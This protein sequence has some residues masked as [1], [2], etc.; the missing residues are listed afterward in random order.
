MNYQEALE[1]I[2]SVN[3]KG[4]RPG[5]GRITELCE[6]LGNPQKDLRFIHVAGTNGKGS[7]C[8]MLMSILRA[9]GYEAGT[10][11]SPYIYKFEERMA[12][13][14]K[15]I[16]PEELAEI[17]SYVAPHAD[18]ME[19][20]PTEFELI[21]AIGFE[22]FKRRGCR[23]VILEAGMGGRLDSTNVIPAPILSVITGIA[24]DHTEYLGDTTEAI[25]KEKAGIIKPGSMV[26]WGG[27]DPDAERVILD[28]ATECECKC[29]G[30]DYSLLSNVKLSIDGTTFDFGR[31]AGLTLPLLG[32]YQ[33]YNA[34]RVITATEILRQGGVKITDDAVRIGLANAKWYG[35]FELMAREPDI[36]FDGAHNPEGMEHAVA[37]IKGYYPDKMVALIMGVMKDKDYE[38]MIKTCAPII[39]HAFTVTP[40]NPRALTA[41]ELAHAF[42]DN[43]IYSTAFPSIEGAL[44]D[45]C[46]YAKKNGVPVFCL[47]SLYSYPDFRRAVKKK[48]Q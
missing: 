1:Y 45:A 3:W 4:S 38:S 23:V 10:F 12:I 46:A 43:G 17:T 32:V 6:R 14:G 26:L 11:T 7:F 13:G 34:A 33:P 22:F 20:A 37:S 42:A 9:A 36:F 24:L 27:D 21:T 30:V 31:Y 5:L 18:A 35:R 39:G 41:E 47:G 44:N 16:S 19:D 2:H 15:P 48:L 25:A 8:A 40:D 29:Y 28:K